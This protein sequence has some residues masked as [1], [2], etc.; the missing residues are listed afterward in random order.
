MSKQYPFLRACCCTAIAL[1]LAA[2]LEGLRHVT[3]PSLSAWQSH[4]AA[5]LVCTAIVFLLAVVGFP[6]ERSKPQHFS[7]TGP[8]SHDISRQAQDAIADGERRYRSLFEN[9]LEGFAYCKMLLDDRGRAMDFVYLDV[10]RAFGELTGLRNVVGKR[11]TEV[12]PRGKDSQ[13]ELFERYG[14]VA[15][16]GKAERFEIEI[17]ALGMWFSISAYGAGER[18]FVA[19]FDNITERKQTE[20]ALRQAEEKYRAIFQDAVVGIFQSTPGG[21]YINAN[22]AMAHMLGYDSPQ[23]LVA[24]IT[25]ISQQV[26]VDPTSR[27]EL[28]RLLREHGLV[29]NF[30]CAVYRKDGSK[31]WFSANVRAI[32]EDGVLVGYEGTNEDITA[33]KLAE[34][35]VQFLAYYDALTGLPNRTLFQDR[36][37]KALAG[38]RRQ[39]CKIALL[40]LDL[41]GFK[42][43]N[44][45]LG[46]AVGDLLLQEVAERLKTWG[47]EQDSVARLGGDEFLVML[48]QVKELP[49]VAVAAERLMDAMTAEFVVQGHS[50]NISCSIGVSIFPEHGADCETLIKQ[51]DAAMYRAKDCGR[52]NFQFFAEDMNVQAVERLRLESSLRLALGKKEL[53]LVYQ[54]QLDVATG[55]ITGLEAL[56]RWQHA[57]LGLVPP[58][59]F[60]RI[61]ENTGLIVPIGEWVLRTACSQAR[62]WQDDGL[63][64][65]SVAVNVSAVQFRQQGFCELIRSVLHE[66]GLAAQC[67][68]LELTESLLLANADV[69]LSVLRELKSMGLTLAIDDFG[70]GYSNFTSLRQFGVSKLKID[71]SFISDVATNP[72]DSAITAAIISMAK[73]LRLKV[74]AEGV[75]NE[76]QMLF[77]R[78]NRCDEIQGYYFSKPLA[79]DKVAGKL[80]GNVAETQ[81]V[82]QRVVDNH[83]NE[84]NEVSVSLMSI[85]LALLV[86]ADPATIQ[87]FSLALRELSISPDACQDAA[88]AA[89][90]LKRRKFDAIIVDL[91]LGKQSG[92]ILDEVH[93]SASNRTAVSFGIG[94]NDAEATAAFRKKSQFVFERPISP[95]SIHKTLKPA[96]GLILRERRRYF[97][98]PVSVAVIIRSERMQEV[99]CNSVNISGGGM[100]LSTQ[101]PFLPGEN[102]RIQFTLPDHEVPLSAEST[103]CWSK[104]GNFGVRF[105][106]ISDEQKSVLQVWLSQKL[107]ETLPEGVAGQFRKAELC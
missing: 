37:G 25:D 34:E 24:S 74:I 72:D 101:V 86:S 67:L 27:K 40:F 70:T 88:S 33:R 45:S 89:L 30:E 23:E 22:P 3:V 51:A 58:D 26:Y 8:Q 61:A 14:R 48:T 99:W 66:T 94:N 17:K 78:R 2:I 103:I 19:V 13:A 98:C 82:R 60:I 39:K 43:I 80:R 32:S 63:P 75:E 18:C 52:N 65:V 12:I 84:P 7:E 96:Y 46:H 59:K 91:Q 64:A 53:F 44:D 5:I 69:T 54:P 85:G 87:Q 106:S 95:Q 81:A 104:T 15:L 35:Q 71:R 11:F 49:D 73:S 76:A 77:L 38:A 97:R 105:A 29:K 107:E 90:L 55:R 31:M 10:N 68:E 100:A 102:V 79:V 4:I 6:C 1:V 42:I 47:R 50:L 36:L 20:Q 9:M 16:T 93:L 21:R 92:L 28:A 41:D 62:K 56:L 83:D 57:A